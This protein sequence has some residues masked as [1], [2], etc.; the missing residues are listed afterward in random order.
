[1]SFLLIALALVAALATYLAILATWTAVHDPTI[2]SVGRVVRIVGAWLLPVGVAVSILR[3]AAELAPESLPSKHLLSPVRWLLRA[4]ERP[5]DLADDHDNY[6]GSG[7]QD[8][9]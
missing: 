3:S 5:N 2:N 7:R 4:S 1:L 6:A 9:D 8:G